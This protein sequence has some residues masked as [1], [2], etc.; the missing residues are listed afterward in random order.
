M[1]SDMVPQN[2]FQSQRIHSNDMVAIS[3]EWAA[4]VRDEFYPFLDVVLRIGISV[5]AR[6]F[7]SEYSIGTIKLDFYSAVR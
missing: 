1:R 7:Y 2:E 5:L 4:T 3:Y 6:L